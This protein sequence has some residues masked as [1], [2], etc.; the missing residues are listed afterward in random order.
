MACL[1]PLRST[2]NELVLTRPN[3]SSKQ[4]SALVWHY[5]HIYI[6]Y[7]FMYEPHNIPHKII[8][9]FNNYN[10]YTIPG[11]CFSSCFTCAG[12]LCLCLVVTVDLLTSVAPAPPNF[13]TESATL[14]IGRLVC[15]SVCV[16]VCVC[17]CVHKLHV[18]VHLTFIRTLCMVLAT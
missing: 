11:E 1:K 9:Q 8:G 6:L 14:V 16:C 18:H 13:F 10:T 3:Y 4:L 17:V 2:D 15:V 5:T 12:E 7:S